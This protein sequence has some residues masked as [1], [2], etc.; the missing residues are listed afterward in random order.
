M[1]GVKI[2]GELVELE[3]RLS[4]DLGF[5]FLEYGGIDANVHLNYRVEHVVANSLFVRT[6]M[7]RICKRMACPC[8]LSP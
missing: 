2:P 8:E 5:A 3:H 1:L 7:K 6:R 4:I